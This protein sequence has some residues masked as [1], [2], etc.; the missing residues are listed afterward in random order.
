MTKNLQRYAQIKVTEEFLLDLLMLPSDM[1]ILDCSIDRLGIIRFIVEHKS[2]A[3][4]DPVWDELPVIVCDVTTVYPN[5]DHSVNFDW[6][7]EESEGG[8]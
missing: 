2:L 5:P 3:E 8:N 6:N 1:N 4:I 7:A